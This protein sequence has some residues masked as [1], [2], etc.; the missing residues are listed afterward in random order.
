MK[1]VN[2]DPAELKLLSQ[3]VGRHCRVVRE[4]WT[5]NLTYSYK[6]RGASWHTIIPLVAATLVTLYQAGWEPMTPIERSGQGWT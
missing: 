4:G 6:L 1:V 2:A 3:L 5:R